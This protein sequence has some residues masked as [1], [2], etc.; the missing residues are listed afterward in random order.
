[1]KIAYKHFATVLSL[2]VAS[3]WSCFEPSCRGAEPTPADLAERIRV[4]GTED[5]GL[6]PVDQAPTLSSSILTE[7]ERAGLVVMSFSRVT[8]HTNGSFTELR[9][10]LDL[11]ATERQ[12]VD[13]LTNAAAIN[14]P[15][16]VQSL[17]LR[18]A[19][20]GTLLHASMVI[21][22]DYR[23]PAAWL[24]PEPDA[25]QTEYRV[26][27]QRRELRQAA[28]DCYK[29]LTSSLP[30]GWQFDRMTLQDGKRLSAQGE[31]PA[32]QVRLL[33]EFRA[34]L[35]KAPAQDGKDLFVP[36]SGEAT[37]R[38]VSPGLTN[39]SWSMQFELR[40]PEPG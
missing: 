31:A 25:A 39:F 28:L 14:S 21:V 8:S 33:E 36:S 4:L 24:S 27:S 6:L 20:N 3:A 26:L 29:L 5:V 10:A 12:L 34:K 23:L 37:M 30:P 11:Q 38:M 17:S 35:E 9:Q 7:A 40:P 19:T 13:F 2:A 18:P 1:M 22:G 32:D 16:R 15:L